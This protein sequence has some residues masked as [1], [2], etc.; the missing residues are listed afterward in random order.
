MM[1]CMRRAARCGAVAL[2]GVLLLTACSSG[3]DSGAASVTTATLAPAVPAHPTF[4]VAVSADHRYLLD[5]D[6]EVMPPISGTTI[7]RTET[8]AVTPLSPE[9]KDGPALGEQY[10][11]NLARLEDQMEQIRSALVK[12]GVQL[13]V[14][15]AYSHGPLGTTTQPLSAPP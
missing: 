13:I 4:P 6:G 1:R 11:S 3:D 12:Q 10:V 8:A 15:V 14:G 9:K 5:Q 2:V 7:V